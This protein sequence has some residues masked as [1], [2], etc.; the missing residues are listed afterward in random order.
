[1]SKPSL[2]RRL[3]LEVWRTGRLFSKSLNLA[4]NLICM[5][6][7]SRFKWLAFLSGDEDRSRKSGNEPRMLH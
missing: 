1:M 5:K 2:K 3:D 7:A 4:C 6:K